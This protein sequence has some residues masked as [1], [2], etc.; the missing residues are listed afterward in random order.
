MGKYGLKIKNYI[1]GSIYEYDLGVRE[2]YDSTKA[3][4]TNSL[5][6][7]YL[8]KIGLETWKEKTTRDVI[9]VDF[10]YGSSS[11]DEQIKKIVKRGMHK[12]QE[13]VDKINSNQFLYDKKTTNELRELYYQ[14]GVDIEYKAY[15]KNG[16]SIKKEK[17][18]YNMLY[19][20]TGKAK[21]GSCMFISDKLYKQ[22]KYFMSMGLE[23]PYDNAQIV[24]FGAYQSL[25]A[26]NIVDRIQI[27][28][29]DILIIKDV[30]SFC[31]SNAI[32]IDVDE[33][34][35]SCAK[36]IEK[37]KM[38]NVLFDGQSLIE[39]SILPS[40]VNGY[41]LLRHHFFKSAAFKTHIQKFMKEYFGNN[42]DNAIVYDM[43]GNKHYAKDIKMITTENSI[44]WI[45]F[46]V[47][48]E[49]WCE[50]VHKNDCKF[51]IVKTA[52]ESKLGSVQKMSYQMINALD[53]NIM[54][55]VVKESVD[56]INL[57]KQDNDAFLKYLS[58]NVNFSNDYDVLI[59]LCKQDPSFARSEYFRERKKNIIETYVTNFRN[60]KVIQNADNLVI[61]GSPY[62]MLLHSVGEDYKK[63]FTFSV[64]EDA[65]QCW[66]S[67][68]NDGE[69]LA[70][71]RSP[72]NSRNNLGCLHNVYSEVY[73]KYFDFGKQI[74]AVNMIETEFQ[75]RNNGSDQDSD[76]VYTTNQIDIVSHARSCMRNYPTIVNNIPKEKVE[77]KNDLLYY[78]QV[79]NK[80]AASAKAIGGASNLAQIAQS[81]DYSYDDES[82]SNYVCILSVLA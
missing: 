2:H 17:A 50:W 72:F 60:G 39:S 27:K 53:I 20:S 57:L 70:E 41:V 28:P 26:S 18:H 32:S 40:W 23:L 15:G 34:R 76:S 24:E 51:G 38:S 67:R 10:S 43:F 75:N 30:E 14:N 22:A 46:G 63:D 78:A 44:K 81:Y 73:D 45:K 47:S 61:V 9:C 55:N 62:A 3:M 25:I 35:Q 49:Y 33:N 7:D 31:E 59:D 82:L 8:L 37:Y 36:L 52:H 54:D 74:V 71:F 13:L 79:D 1:A 12:N 19:R 29:E 16:S 56:Y 48:Y 4:L 64:E 68:F 69:Y 77:Y 80:L 66:T 42:Y 21:T 58:E 11:Y 65:I 5:L 6:L